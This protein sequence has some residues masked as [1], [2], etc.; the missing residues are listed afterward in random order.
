ML[1]HGE[2]QFKTLIMKFFLLEKE[3]LGQ[4]NMTTK[5]LIHSDLDD[6]FH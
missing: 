6:A 3:G 4:K 2:L 5:T 1:L